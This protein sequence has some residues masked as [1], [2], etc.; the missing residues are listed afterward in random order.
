M[1]EYVMHWMGN[2]KEY[3][4]R[5]RWKCWIEKKEK[6]RKETHNETYTQTHTP[7]GVKK[8]KEREKNEEEKRFVV[9]LQR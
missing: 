2:D 8:M 5:A 1:I 7:N 9:S 6:K 3:K 4:E